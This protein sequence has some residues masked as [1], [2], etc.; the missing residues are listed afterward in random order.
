MI[1]I[2]GATGH[3]GYVVARSLIAQGET[4]RALARSAKRV[5]T[6]GL[7][8]SSVIYGDLSDVESLRGCFQ[9]CE[10]VIHA[11][12]HI[13]LGHDRAKLQRTNVDGTVSV[14][15]ACRLEGVE[16]LIAVGSVEAFDLSAPV[17][18]GHGDRLDPV[19]PILAY[20]KSK[21][22]AVNATLDANDSELATLVISPTAILGPWDF[23]PSR[24]GRF[25]RS[26]ILRR[27]P[28]FVR[29]GFDIVD[30]RDVAGACI[31]AIR[32]GVPGTHYV[33]SGNYVEVR[34]L[35]EELEELSGVPKPP[36]EVPDRIGKLFAACSAFVVSLAGGTPLITPA[37]VSLL[38]KRIRVSSELA[39]DDLHF[40]ARELRTTVADTIAWFRGEME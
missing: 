3:L 21:A 20:G 19:L 36:L 37:A 23:R 24:M 14:I 5:E 26:F 12:A 30:V 16:R 38:S 1:G 29:G 15:E 8:A 9:G 39:R 32:G 7:P 27:L 31:G 10:A 6:V 35:L 33:V 11:A 28:A 22:E 13:S 17:V 25:V 4:I 40:H 18:G 34:H 2:T